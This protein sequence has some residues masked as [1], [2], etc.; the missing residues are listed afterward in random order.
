VI[1]SILKVQ[2]SN[3]LSEVDPK[4]HRRVIDLVREAGVDVSDWS[5]FKNGP[6]PER[7]ASNPKYCYEWAFV[8]PGKVVVLN[9]WFDSMEEQGESLRQEINPR[10]FGIDM[11]RAGRKTWERRASRM[12]RCIQ[13]SARTKIPIRVIVCQGEMRTAEDPDSEPSHVYRRALDPKPWAITFYDQATGACVVTRGAEPDRFTDQFDEAAGD[14]SPEQRD[15]N[16]KVFVRSAEVRK[17]VLRRAAGLCEFCGAPGFV[18]YD[19]RI[20]LETHHVIPLSEKGGDSEANV[21]AL[22]PNH[23]REAHYSNRR[24]T[25]RGLLQSKVYEANS[26]AMQTIAIPIAAQE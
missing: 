3:V 9:L 20:F 13:Q 5:N 11:G 15:A 4:G 10:Q 1:S 21:I 6:N 7:A 12:D 14:H 22:C 19:G 8:E 23:H 16:G 18:K 25:M 2:M 24:V 17:R 26:R